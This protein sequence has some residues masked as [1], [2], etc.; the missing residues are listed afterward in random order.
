[1]KNLF[2][3]QSETDVTPEQAAKSLRR[4]PG[5][6]WMDTALP[7]AGAFSLLAAEPDLVMQGHLTRDGAALERELARRSRE[8]TDLGYP[9]GAA[10]GWVGF[11]GHFCFGFYEN[12][13]LYLHGD[14]RWV[15]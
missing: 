3:I 4:R 7:S 12:L 13:H 10:V 14:D 5:F 2:Q 15:N 6:V 1:M 8:S 11:D 9:Q